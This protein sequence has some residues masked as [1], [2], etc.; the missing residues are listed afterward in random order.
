MQVEW[1]R[2]ALKN[3]DQELE[4]IAEDNPLAARL[5][6]QR[7]EHAVKLLSDNPSLGRSGRIP[8]THELVVPKTRYIIPYRVRPRLSRVE[9][10]RVFHSSRKPPDHW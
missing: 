4:H 8:G 3:L 9:I 6:A 7:I 1:L 5:V 10:L 2:K